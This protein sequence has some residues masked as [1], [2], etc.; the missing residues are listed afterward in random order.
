MVRIEEIKKQ[1][2]LYYTLLALPLPLI[3]GVLAFV[4]GASSTFAIALISIGLI[5]VVLPSMILSFLEFRDIKS[6]E[7]NFPNF[8]DDLSQ[9]SSA[10]MNLPQAISVASKTSYGKLTSHI[11]QLNIWLT[12]NM[13]FPVAWKKFTKRLD[14]SPLIRRVNG[15]IIE[16]FNGGGDVNKTLGS[17]AADVNIIKDMEAERRSIMQQQI[18]IMYIIFFVFIGVIIALYKII[19]SLS[20]LSFRI[21]APIWRWS[22]YSSN[23]YITEGAFKAYQKSHLKS[24]K[25]AIVF[26][27][28][29]IVLCCISNYIG[30]GLIS[31]SYCASTSHKSTAA[32]S[33][34]IMMIIKDHSSTTFHGPSNFI[35]AGD[36]RTR[37]P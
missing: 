34:I 25:I 19:K 36:S 18:V 4:F 17:L 6:S 15:I 23:K 24:T 12:W 29:F 2:K 35:V 10:G 11:K 9:S 7:D 1:K 33:K 21:I 27:T 3:L 5:I 26:L 20:G 32:L 28:F 30:C 16:A 31:A 22:L 13:A 14:A 37:F 8:L